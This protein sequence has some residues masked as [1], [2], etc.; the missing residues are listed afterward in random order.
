[1]YRKKDLSCFV[2]QN[3]LN[4]FKILNIPYTFLKQ[5]PTKWPK[6]H[7]FQLALK[8]VKNLKIVND[9]AERAV[10]LIQTFNNTITK[11]EEQKQYLLKI[12]MEHGKAFPT[13]AKKFL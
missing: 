10:S 11:N 13:P 3:S 1:M 6:L 8:V 7:D 5:S 9:N 4:F 12:V 2:T